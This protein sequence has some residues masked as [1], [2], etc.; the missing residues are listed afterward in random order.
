MRT[1]IIAL[2]ILFIMMTC[3]YA[4]ND[5]YHDGL[6]AELQTDYG[7][8][9]GSWILTPNEVTNATNAIS[10]GNQ[11]VTLNPAPGQVFSQAVNLDV[12]GSG[13][14]PWDVG[15]YNENV[16][17]IQQ[18]DRVLTVVWLRTVST[19]LAAPGKI[20][21]YAERP[22]TYD[23]EFNLT[24]NPSPQWQ[25]YLIPFEATGDFMPAQLRVGY[26]LAF[27]EQEIEFGGIA[28]IKL[29]Q[30]LNNDYYPGIEANAPW[31]TAA[32]DRIEL[33]RKADLDLQVLD[34]AGNPI[35]NANVEIEM[36]RHHY[37]F[38]TAVDTRKLA[39]NSGFDQTYQDNLLNLDGQ[40][41]GFNWVVTENA[42]KWDAWEEGWA[43]TQAETVNAIEGLSDNKIK[44]RGHGL[45]WPGWN[46]MR[47]I[48]S[49]IIWMKY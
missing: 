46:L 1:K 9:G 47:L 20:T 17:A 25:Q 18:G 4:Q 30:E 41:H 34:A 7:L 2:F 12:G 43:G 44:A 15:Y 6:L 31:R 22:V 13:T 48:A 19:A 10:Y 49:M 29:P 14:N 32:A 33:H 42:L 27:Q 8:T 5:A 11:V 23:K 39:N 16:N 37:A 28:L 38:G 36:L 21:M 24:V 45:L 35:P 3:A 40:G 26:H